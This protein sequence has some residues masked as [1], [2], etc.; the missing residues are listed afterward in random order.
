MPTYFDD[1]P[2]AG[3]DREKPKDGKQPGVIAQFIYQ[4]VVTDDYQGQSRTYEK[5]SVIVELKEMSKQYP[6][7]RLIAW[8]SFPLKKHPKSKMSALLRELYGTAVADAPDFGTGKTLEEI[9]VGQPV[10]ADI[11]CKPQNKYPTVKLLGWFGDNPLAVSENYRPYE[12]RQEAGEDQREPG[13]DDYN[14]L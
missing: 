10:I 5:G 9:F 3:G 2:N 13:S 8:Y 14:G 7:Q 6:D 4:G 1:L 11:V 12:P